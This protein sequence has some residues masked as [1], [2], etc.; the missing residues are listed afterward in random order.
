MPLSEHEQR[1]L[2]EMERSLYRN[3][4]DFVATVNPRRGR[5]NYT[6]VV[7]GV[8]LGV[9]G[10]ATLVLG[11]VFNLTIVGMLGFVVMLA[12]VLVAVTPSRR[13]GPAP[14][15]DAG[16]KPKRGRSGSGFMESLNERWDRRQE[17]RD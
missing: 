12:G 1:L 17:G 15:E 10:I 13:L 5:P 14:A 4:A 9:V 2:E 16:T 11:V 3:D 6:A 7:L 8:L